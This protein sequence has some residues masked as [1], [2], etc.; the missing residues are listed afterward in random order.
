MNILTSKEKENETNSNSFARIND[1]SMSNYELQVGKICMNSVCDI[2]TID[3]KSYI[4]YL[5]FSHYIY[6]LTI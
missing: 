4:G 3:R 2:R 5:L 1:Q 6:N